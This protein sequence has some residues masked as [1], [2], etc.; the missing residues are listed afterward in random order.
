M[1]C[2]K[3][4]RI[5]DKLYNLQGVLLCTVSFSGLLWLTKTMRN[6]LSIEMKLKKNKL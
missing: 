4:T 6:F 2:N 3:K 1:C 5:I